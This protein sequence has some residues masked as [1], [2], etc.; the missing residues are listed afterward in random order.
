MGNEQEM[1]AS[2]IRPSI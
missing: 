2:K 1:C